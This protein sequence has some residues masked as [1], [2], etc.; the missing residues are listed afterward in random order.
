[1]RCESSVSVHGASR[2]EESKPEGKTGVVQVVED[3][4]EKAFREQHLKTG[5]PMSILFFLL[6]I[7]FKFNQENLK[8]VESS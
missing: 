6:N 4:T 3:F 1:M 7:G 8:G 5:F 2:E